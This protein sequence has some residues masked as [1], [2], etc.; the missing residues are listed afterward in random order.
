MSHLNVKLNNRVIMPSI[1]LGVFKTASRETVQSVSQAIEMGYRHIDT[2]SIY[3]NEVEVGLAIKHASVPRSDIFVTTK[4][5]RD[6]IATG[7]TTEAVEKSLKLLNLEYIDQILLHW[8]EPAERLNAWKQLESIY[9]RGLVKSIGVSN[10]MERHLRELI[11]N[12]EIVPAVNQ[13]EVHPFL[14]QNDVVDFCKRMDITVC[15]YSPLAK[16]RGL[17]HPLVSL[18]AEKNSLSPSQVLLSWNLSKGNVVIPKSTD[19]FRQKWKTLNCWIAWK[20][21]K[22][23]VGTLDMLL[24]VA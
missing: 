23:Q 22:P 20:M 19:P 24:N 10:F 15:A 13:L 8:P 12:A 4:V 17:S 7:N 21:A 9:K 3:G 2:A 18:I 1:G 14:Q 5:W 16:S 11:N 6:D